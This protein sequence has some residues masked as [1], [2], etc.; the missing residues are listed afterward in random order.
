MTR[1]PVRTALVE[2]LPLAAPAV[3]FGLVMG[4]AI[5]ESPIDNL[6]GW[7]SSPIVFAGAAQLT[8][9]TLL[10]AGPVVGA[11]VAALVVNS[12]HIMYSVAIAETFSRQPRWFRWLGPY[13]LVDQIFALSMLHSDSEPGWFRTYYLTASGTLWTMWHASVTLGLVVGSSVP[14]EW[15]LDFAVPI[16]FATLV[17]LGLTRR[18]AVVAAAVGLLVGA[19]TS[20]LPNRVSILIGAFAGVMAGTLVDREGEPEA[21]S[22]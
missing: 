2:V 4:I 9:I 19:A 11:V 1:P 21:A 17:V 3:P 6:L 5:T 20:P 22:S 7:L 12:R 18:P 15:Q 10:A 16:L 14:P 8:L 13:T